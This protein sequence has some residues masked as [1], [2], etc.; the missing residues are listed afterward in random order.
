MKESLIAIRPLAIIEAKFDLEAKQND[1]IDMLFTELNKDDGKLEYEINIEKYKSYYSGDTSNIY[2]D[3]KKGVKM[4]ERSKG[5]TIYN[6]ITE[7]E[8]WYSWFSKIT[9][10]NKEGRIIVRLDPEFKSILTEVKRRISYD[11]ENTLKCVSKYSKRLY[12]YL[13][14]FEN[15]G[16]R[17]DN[18][19]DLKEKLKVPK[20]Y[21]AY[22]KFKE[23]VLDIAYRE[24]NALTD[25]NFDYEEIRTGKKIVRIKFNISLKSKNVGKKIILDKLT[26][27]Y[28]K[29]TADEK[30]LSQIVGS[31][32]NEDEINNVLK[33]LNMNFPKYKNKYTDKMGYLQKQIKYLDN[34]VATLKEYKYNALLIDAIKKDY[35]GQ[36]K[37]KSQQHPNSKIKKEKQLRFNNLASGRTYDYEE[38]ENVALGYSEYDPDKIYKK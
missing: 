20:S 22:G 36:L 26:K 2:R 33:A 9:Y 8:E 37:Q 35:Y 17:I 4:F 28:P 3:L 23:R 15:T 29:M 21:M 1:I 7:Q 11:I 30:E 24:I 16:W 27:N 38:L 18:I 31:R 6:P 5:V 19:E 14:S 32:I 12:Y 34:Y 13:K 10:V 25:I